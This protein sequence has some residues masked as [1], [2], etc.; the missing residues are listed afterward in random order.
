MFVYVWTW[1]KKPLIT[2]VEHGTMQDVQNVLSQ[3]AVESK[4]VFSHRVL[5]EEISFHQQTESKQVNG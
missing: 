1:P 5:L 3:T 2:D 4:K